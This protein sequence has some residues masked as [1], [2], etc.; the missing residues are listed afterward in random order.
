MPSLS[1]LVS[2]KFANNGRKVIVQELKESLP[3]FPL[4]SKPAYSNIAFSLLASVVTNVT[5]LSYESAIEKYIVQPLDLNRTSFSALTEAN[6]VIPPLESANG[7]WEMDFATYNAAGGA[8][9]T[10][11]DLSILVRALISPTPKILPQQAIDAWLKP[12]AFGTRIGEA[13]GFPWEITRTNQL[14][15]RGVVDIYA[16]DGGIPGYTSRFALLPAFGVGFVVLNGGD[17]YTTVPA[18][19]EAVLAAAFPAVEAAGTREAVQA[20]YVGRFSA[21]KNN[22]M[23]V[24]MDG[25]GLRLVALWSNGVDF[26]SRAIEIGGVLSSSWRLYPTG[27]S[28]GEDEDWRVV[29][30]EVAGPLSELPSMGVFA[31][32]C[33]SWQTVDAVTYGG[34]SV[35]KIVFKKKGGKVVAVELSAFRITMKRDG[36]G[37]GRL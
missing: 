19:A 27:I 4:H 23:E 32:A 8:Y 11:H 36:K 12:L 10:T 15:H 17:G 24:V 13:V 33:H 25:D 9:S 3:T 37:R 1:D 18:L 16:K 7:T 21:G 35:D 2:L 22:W 29:I 20:G 14:S 26:Y 28:N 30:D 34:E 6:M 31:G 5:G